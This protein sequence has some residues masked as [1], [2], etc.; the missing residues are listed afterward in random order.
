MGT[1]HKLAVLKTAKKKLHGS[2]KS[3]HAY[4]DALIREHGEAQRVAP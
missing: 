2:F 4:L 3:G 1:E